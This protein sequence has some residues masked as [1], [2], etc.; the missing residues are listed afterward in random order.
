MK[1]GEIERTLANARRS[2]RSA[3]NE[4]GCW[5]GELSSSALS[6]ATAIAAL[7][8]V[9][10]TAN[11]TLIRKGASWLLEHQ[12]EDGGWG[13]TTRSFSNISTTLLCWSALGLVQYESSASQRAESWV[14]EYVGSSEPDAI[15]KAVTERY[16]KDRTF[17]VPILMM[18]AIGGKLG[19]PLAAWRRVLPLPFELSVLPR[20]F[21]AAMR[22]PVVSYALPA[23]IAIGFARFRHVQPWFPF[24]LIRKLAWRKASI[25]LEKIQPESGGFLEATPLTSFVTMALASSG[26]ASHP[27]ARQ[28]VAFIRDSIREDGSWP[29]D[30]N[31][32]T[33]CTTLAIKA[34]SHSES[35]FSEEERSATRGWLER[36]QYRERHPYTDAAPGGWAWTD[37]SGGVPD[38]DDT[39]GA[40]L[41]LQILEHPA[42]EAIEAG[43]IWLLDLQNGDGG[44]PTFCKGWGAFPFD[45]SSP[46]ITAHALRAFSVWKDGVGSKLAK[47]IERST[48]RALHFLEKRQEK[49]GS[50]QPLWFGNQ[51][52]SEENNRVYGTAMTLLALEALEGSSLAKRME[53]KARAWLQAQQNEDGGWGGETGCPSSLEET[54]LALDALALVADRKVLERGVRFIDQRTDGGSRFFAAPIGFYFAKLWYFEALYPTIWVVSALGRIAR[55]LE[56]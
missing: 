3:R 39:A 21:F 17:A 46:D 34:L 44:M 54:A 55:R 28:G 9:D 48:T 16:G 1:I 2:L 23:L 12:N 43:L 53:T 13:D 41:A 11:E 35:D 27:V 6:T 42:D 30:T 52:S 20:R 56:G 14:F 36:Q 7:H 51:H 26:E 8:L 45:R 5:E 18:C 40:L 10:G 25:L 37:L 29:I 47:R 31:L 49:A 38:A 19:E 50:W 4:A 22:L 33:W 15:A 32:A 24:C